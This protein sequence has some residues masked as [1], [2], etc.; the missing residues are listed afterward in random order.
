[1]TRRIS[2]YPN[3]L[4][5]YVYPEDESIREMPMGIRLHLPKPFIRKSLSENSGQQVCGEGSALKA[6]VFRNVTLDF[7]QIF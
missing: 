5:F 4:Y 7:V 2:F 3:A 6:D 1:M